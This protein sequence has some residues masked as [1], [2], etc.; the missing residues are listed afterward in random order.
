MKKLIILGSSRSHGNTYSIVKKL[1]EELD[2]DLLDLNTKSI[3]YYDYD[4]NN[5][6]DDYIPMVK[7]I[8]E[9]YDTLIFATPVYWY[10]MS[11]Q[12]KAFFDRLSDFIRVEKETGRKLRGK[13]MAAL[14]CSSGALEY[15]HFF[16]PF[17]LS[18]DYLGMNYLG[19][20]H[21]WVEEE[22]ISSEVNGRIN[23][24]VELLS[25]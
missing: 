23:S 15:P 19:D 22:G 14:C 3:G 5:S 12:M 16:E 25:K 13:S 4:Y 9:N 1:Q 7:N 18:A 11:A 20:L 21:T 8:L 6:K 17:K 2:C 24:F 10:T